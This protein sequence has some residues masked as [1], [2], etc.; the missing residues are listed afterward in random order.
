MFL[1]DVNMNTLSNRIKHDIKTRI[2]I[3]ISI[4][5]MIPIVFAIYSYINTIN[6]VKQEIYSECEQLGNYVIGQHLVNNEDAIT[7]KLKSFNNV[8][9]Y[10]VSWNVNKFVT[11]PT[12]KIKFFQFTATYPLQLAANINNKDLGYFTITGNIS[13][14]RVVSNFLIEVVFILIIFAFL[15]YFLLIPVA[16]QIPKKLILDP[17]QHILEIIQN[18]TAQ[19]KQHGISHYDELQDIEIKIRQ[20]IA[21][22]KEQSKDAAVGILAKK[23]V[24][25][26]K[27]PLNLMQ[28]CSNELKQNSNIDVKLIKSLRL[29]IDNIKYILINLLDVETK[30]KPHDDSDNPRYVLLKPILDEII[31]HKN[32]EWRDKIELSFNDYSESMYIWL[33][34]VPYD[35]KNKISNLFDN[36]YESL[37]NQSRIVLNIWLSSGM[38]K[39][40]ICDNGCGMTTKMVEMVCNGYS[41]KKN[42]HGIGLSTAISYFKNL[43]GFLEV[44]SKPNHGTQIVIQIPKAIEP[45]WFSP[46]IVLKDIVIV[47][48]DDISTHYYLQSVLFNIKNVKY[49]LK[50]DEFKNWMS[51][52]YAIINNVTYLIDNQIDENMETG[53]ELIEFYNISKFS[54]LVTNEYDNHYVQEKAMQLN[55]KIIPKDLLGLINK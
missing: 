17:I 21:L 30:I 22:V 11:L 19:K 48:D 32:I 34:L 36:A 5:S 28:S 39:I 26:I 14:Q 25:D 53:I 45:I 49:F 10:N 20:L 18:D 31:S 9:S 37:T 8:H 43:N 3:A 35:F 55:L 46:N 16:T 52:N 24:H 51:C 40:E 23:I 15:L 33:Y 1:K 12:F 13:L 38:V 7:Y 29:A 54:Y 42:G 27:S 47:L 4:I 50:V 6:T 41:T 44:F 2:Y